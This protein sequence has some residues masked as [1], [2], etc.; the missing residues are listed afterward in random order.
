MTQQFKP[1]LFM[2]VFFTFLTG[3]AY[4]MVATIGAQM[5]FFT[6]ANG[7]FI[8]KDSQ[9]FG[10]DLIGQAFTKPGYFWGR[11][12]ATAPD[13]YNAGASSGSNLGPSNQS[14]VVAVKSRLAA[15]HAADPGNNAP[16]PIDL[17]SAS[18]SGL[19]PHISPAAAEYQAKRISKIRKIDLVKLHEL[20]QSNT[21]SRQWG[22]F[23]E[24]RVNILKLNL[25]LDTAH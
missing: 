16:V 20:V 13:P 7:S 23:G 17:I 2:L 1:A 9:T 19:D 21:E 24:P 22:I 10:S 15:L 6:E 3:I 18:A 14:L 12:S 5:F 8:V 11:P 4:P 25:A